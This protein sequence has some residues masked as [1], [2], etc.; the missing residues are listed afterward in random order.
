M[1]QKTYFAVTT[2]IFV[3]IAVLHLTR[4][5]TGWEASMGGWT[6]PR[7]VSWVAFVGSSL[8]AYSGFNLNK[9]SQ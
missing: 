9:R 1:N 4:I 5:F 6:V 8:L 7:W 2:L 3:I